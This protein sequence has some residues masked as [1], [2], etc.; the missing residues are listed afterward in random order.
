MDADKKLKE[1]MALKDAHVMRVDSMHFAKGRDKKGNERLEIRYFDA[2]AN[3]LKEFYYLDSREK[4]Q[5][6][7][8]TFARMH[9][10][11][12]ELNLEVHTVAD[13]LALENRYR[14][15]MFLIARKR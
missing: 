8:L 15:P 14:P 7:Y 1:A 13:V 3:E 6:F 11:V 2:D 4:R 10:R 9:L 12:P 5:A